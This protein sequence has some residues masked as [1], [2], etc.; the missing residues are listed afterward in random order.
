MTAG[1]FI[2]S[3]FHFSSGHTA[4]TV[5]LLFMLAGVLSVSS[6]LIFVRRMRMPSTLLLIIGS[7][8]V[9]LCAI[10]LMFHS[11]MSAIVLGFLLLGIGIG[12]VL[13]GAT[14]SASLAV[15]QTEQGAL[16]G[17]ISASQGLGTA[18]GPLIG[19]SLYNLNHLLPYI[20]VGVLFSIASVFSWF[21][22]GSGRR[23]YKLVGEQ[24]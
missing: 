15:N 18:F 3:Y 4:E 1:F 10:S 7:P 13:P 17:R 20:F 12:F 24:S 22:Y 8:T 11:Y 5:G 19:T 16:A 9:L 21:H 23:H 2:E 6:Q 14:S